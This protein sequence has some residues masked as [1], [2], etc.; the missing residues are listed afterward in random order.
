M[1]LVITLCF[2]LLSINFNASAQNKDIQLGKIET[3]L[4]TILNQDKAIWIY[5]P[6]HDPLFAYEK[7][8]YPVIYLL[9]AG[10]F[11]VGLSHWIF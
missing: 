1:K 4:S 9:D 5:Q 8:S 11:D 2:A 6:E 10:F 3:I 7:P